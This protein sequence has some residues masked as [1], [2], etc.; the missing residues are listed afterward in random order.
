MVL[1]RVEDGYVIDA[2]EAWLQLTGFHRDEVIGKTAREHGIWKSLRDREE[3]V[4]ELKETGSIRNRECACVR[5]NGEGA[6][7]PPVGP[8]GEHARGVGPADF[9]D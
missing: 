9:G 6:H 4:R 8:D 2:N 1:T 3:M 7:G 5:R